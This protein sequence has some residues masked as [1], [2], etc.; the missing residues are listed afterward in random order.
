[1][2]RHPSLSTQSPPAPLPTAGDIGLLD[3]PKGGTLRDYYKY[4]YIIIII[5]NIIIIIV[6]IIIIII[7]IVVIIIIIIIIIPTCTNQP[8]QQDRNWIKFCRERLTTTVAWE[9]DFQTTLGKNNTKTTTAT[10]R[11]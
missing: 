8:L 2:F 4:Y 9:S 3:T 10:T 5:I 7:I 6:I 1:M 11:R